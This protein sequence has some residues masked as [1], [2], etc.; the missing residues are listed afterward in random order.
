MDHQT[1]M[2]GNGAGEPPVRGVARSAG[3]LWHH[4][5][6]LGELQMRLLAVE[7]AEGIR[8]AKTG[9]VLLATG[10]I[11]AM[12][13]LPVLLVSAALVLVEQTRLTPAEAFSLVVGISLVIAAILVGGGLWHLRNNSAG[14]PLSRTEWKVNWRWLK[15]TLRQAR[16]SRSRLP[17]DAPRAGRTTAESWEPTHRS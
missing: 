15:E 7:L 11:L 6:L 12:V 2:N 4:I 10:L 8:R 13:T 1:Q 14:L 9:T 5:L 3:E 16:A 17:S